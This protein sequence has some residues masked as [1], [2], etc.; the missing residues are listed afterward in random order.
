[1]KSIRYFLSALTA[2]AI[3][4]CGYHLGGLKP[5]N[6]ENMNTFCVEVFENYS[7]Q[8][9]AG[10]LMTTA[11]A[12]SLQSDGTYRMA[13]RNEADFIVKGEVSHISRDSLITST[14][15]SYVSTHI[16]LTVHTKYEVIDRKTGKKLA[17]G[18]ADGVG[19]YFN[20][21]GNTQTSI[22]TTLS[23]ATRSAADNVT[24][25]LTTR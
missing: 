13:S 10:M 8:P 19:S 18:S 5:Q 6:M 11:M 24:L 17:R 23:Y 1:M 4:S 14:E 12:N 2:L 21:V 22:E 7:S 20:Q 16:S 9:N 15:D 25:S 3:S